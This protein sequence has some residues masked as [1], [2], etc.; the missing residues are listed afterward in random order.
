M[1][2]GEKRFKVKMGEIVSA[3]ALGDFHEG[4]ANVDYPALGRAVEQIRLD[5]KPKIVFLMGDLIEAIMPDDKRWS[6]SEVY[7][8]YALR[9]LKNL[10]F[11]Q[12]DNICKIL[13]PIKEFVVAILVGNHEE[14]YIK[15]HFGDIYKYIGDKFPNAVRLGGCGF[16][17]VILDI[18]ETRAFDFALKH[19]V[20][21][22]GKM[23]GYVINKAR[24][25]F[26]FELADFC[27]MGHLHKLKAERVRYRMLNHTGNNI[28]EKKMWYG[29]SG[30]FKRTYVMGNSDWYE[31]RGREE[32]DVGYLKAEMSIT[33]PHKSN[34][35]RPYVPITKL[36]RVFLD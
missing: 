32:A 14:T 20:S 13:E 23:M 5:H 30:T 28:I 29:V 19:G 6:P 8:D 11:K 26:E 31:Q 33:R 35:D 15:R 16:F 21:G 27:I 2:S 9:D 7:K 24:E 36:D 3:Y 34:F 1:D 22:G 12:A 17:R 18:G 25:S 10:P 4:N